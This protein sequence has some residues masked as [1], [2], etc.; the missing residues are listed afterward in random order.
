MRTI[1]DREDRMSAAVSELA[2]G[3][4]LGPDN[5]EAHHQYAQALIIVGA[6]SAALA[7]YRKALALEPGRAVSYEEIARL[8]IIQGRFPDAL[9]YADSAVAAEPQLVRGWMARARA[10]LALGDTPAADRDVSAAAALDLSVRYAVEATSM[11]AMVLVVQG[12]TARARALV[13][14][15]RG[16][17]TI[18]GNEA[19]V[20]VGQAD[21]VL[22][23]IE[24]QSVGAALCYQLR[25][26]LLRVLR[27]Q[28]HYDRLAAQCPR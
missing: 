25:F 17:F 6:D 9:A 28:P 1:F 7:E 23:D 16:Q 15:T 21:Q 27:G 18:Y 24:R 4:Q 12:D 8:M 22:D 5:A 26:P 20:A 2:R 13:A 19:M 14:T 3:V 10:H 11:R